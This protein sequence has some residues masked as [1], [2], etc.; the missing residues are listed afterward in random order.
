MGRALMMGIGM[1][2]DVPGL[3]FGVKDG[4]AGIEAVIAGEH[5]ANAAGQGKI[6]HTTI[7][8]QFNRQENRRQGAVGGAAEHGHQ[9]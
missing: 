3:Q 1:N 7:A 9:S 5:I 8:K 6:Q 4:L 2:I